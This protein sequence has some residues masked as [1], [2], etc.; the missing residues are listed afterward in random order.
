VLGR[1]VGEPVHVISR[2]VHA[3]L[4]RLARQVLHALGWIGRQPFGFNRIGQDTRQHTVRPQH[5]GG[6]GTLGSH[7]GDPCLDAKTV[8]VRHRYLS[9]PW[10]NVDTPG[11][12]QHPVV[13]QCGLLLLAGQPLM[14]QFGHCDPAQRR[15]DVLA[16][17]FRDFH[18]GGE[19]PSTR[20]VDM[21]AA[22]GVSS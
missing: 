5:G 2:Q 19:A 18:S 11:R 4:A 7:A 20:G 12:L 15:R 10:R 14:S 17:S 1:F 22:E 13:G 3:P 9:P 8:D 6:T 16:F 21:L